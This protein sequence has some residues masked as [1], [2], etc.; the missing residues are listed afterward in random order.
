LQPAEAAQ[1]KAAMKRYARSNARRASMLRGSGPIFRNINGRAPAAIISR[2]GLKGANCGDAEISQCDSNFI[3]NKG[4]ASAKDVFNLIE[5]V[6]DKARAERGIE[7]EL[8]LE[9]WR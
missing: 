8:A 2:L 9:V 6:R 5:M 1:L 4:A 3:I 7:L